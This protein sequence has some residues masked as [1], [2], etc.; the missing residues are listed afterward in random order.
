MYSEERI[1][2]VDGVG[3]E[4]VLEADEEGVGGRS[5]AAACGVL[6]VLAVGREGCADG[7]DGLAR[8]EALCEEHAP[9]EGPGPVDGGPPGGVPAS[10]GDALEEL[11]DALGDLASVCGLLGALLV[12]KLDL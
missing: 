10:R 3:A 5:A 6:G 9:V 11:L 8:K 1:F 7:L 12:E 2:D 4:V